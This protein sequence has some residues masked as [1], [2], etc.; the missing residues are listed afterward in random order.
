MIGTEHPVT[1]E[2]VMAFLDGELPPARAEF[3]ATHLKGCADCQHI[4]HALGIAS[5][6]MAAW[7]IGTSK[8][9]DER[10]L[11]SGAKRLRSEDGTGISLRRLRDMM[12]RRW[13]WAPALSLVVAFVAF[14]V[15]LP[16]LSFVRKVPPQRDYVMLERAS[17][18][19]STPNSKAGGGGGGDAYM[20]SELRAPTVE[21][22][23]RVSDS[24]ATA[25][26]IA[27]TVSLSIVVKDFDAART[28]LD[29]IL[30]RHHGYAAEMTANTEKGE[31][32]SLS[33]S[34]RIPASELA[35][36]TS[37]L[38]AL[39][40]VETETQ[41]G[42]EVTTQHADLVA[43]LKNARETEQRLINVLRT[44]TGKVSDV[45]E[46]EQEIARVRVGI[47]QM[48]AERKAVEHRVDF[49]T[50]DLKLKEEY[51][52]QLE[53]APHSVAT[54]LR[55]SLVT[56][57]RDAVESLVGLLLFLAEYGPALLLWAF[58]L[59]WPVRFIWRRMR[60]GMAN[61]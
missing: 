61:A 57:Y 49:A 29:A 3:L 47:E 38:K 21:N 33:A 36:A 17:P 32:R 28:A 53:L 42:E 44:R 16:G 12:S 14:I 19:P 11:L 24:N 52:A 22:K 58:L 9:L 40:R 34:L 15:W 39:G 20:F 41:K 18:S 45:L 25:P 60:R 13:V 26:M 6:G 8:R 50:V 54:R 1:P 51:K 48:E 35:A 7:T 31:A 37:E 5:Q 2:E 4:E 27:R 23:R 10:A 59:F 46:V 56:G 55:N 30:A 43:R